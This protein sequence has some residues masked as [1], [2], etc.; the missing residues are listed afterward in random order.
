MGELCRDA[1]TIYAQG[2]SDCRGKCIKVAVSPPIAFSYQSL[3]LPQYSRVV[4]SYDRMIGVL[5]HSETVG[6]NSIEQSAYLSRHSL[7]YQYHSSPWYFYPSGT[8]HDGV[9]RSN[10]GKR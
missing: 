7:L 5:H 1:L 6:R 9:E 8:R 3:D 2:I 10:F 4:L